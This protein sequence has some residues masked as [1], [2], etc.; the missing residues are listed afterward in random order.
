M[1]KLAIHGGKPVR[2]KPF[3]KWPKATKEVKNAIIGTVDNEN[4]GVGSE[5][6]SSFEKKFSNFQDS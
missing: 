2:K 5:A 3:P 6:I 1:T 4:W